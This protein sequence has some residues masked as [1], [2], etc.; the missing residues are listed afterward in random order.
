MPRDSD[1]QTDSRGDLLAMLRNDPFYKRFDL[2]TFAKL[3]KTTRFAS[4][5][6]SALTA[7]LEQYYIEQ[8]TSAS[9]S[10]SLGYDLDQTIGLDFIAEWATKN[11]AEALESYEA[12]KRSTKRRKRE[13]SGYELNLRTAISDMFEALASRFADVKLAVSDN[14][15]QLDGEPVDKALYHTLCDVLRQAS[16]CYIVLRDEIWASLESGKS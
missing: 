8:N 1:L 11:R 6:N 13:I 9:F 3:G 7:K 5:T 2:E 4:T 14:V 15:V 10:L 16:A 12:L